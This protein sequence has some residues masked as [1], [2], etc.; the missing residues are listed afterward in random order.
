[1]H[2]WQSQAAATAMHGKEQ[3]APEGHSLTV[4]GGTVVGGT[5]VGGTVVGGMVAGEEKVWGELC[6]G[7]EVCMSS[8][9]D[10]VY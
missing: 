1:M 7:G 9:P 10:I 4:L 2:G 3:G 6:A 8:R 5:V